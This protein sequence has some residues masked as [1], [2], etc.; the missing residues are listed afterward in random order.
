MGLPD[1]LQNDALRLSLVNACTDLIDTQVAAKGGLGGMALKTT[2]G[3]V[4]SVGPEYIP[5]AVGRL[6]PEVL[7]AL[8]PI[9]AEGLQT[10]SP[11][12]YLMAQSAR[13]ADSLLSVTD[14]R[15]VK[16]SN[17]LVK[18]SYQRLRQSV[19]G[20]VEAAVP[21]LAQI[22]ANHTSQPS[23]TSLN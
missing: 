15:I 2:Y 3:L 13:T 14:D 19:K 12:A 17:G 6:L 7:A 18:A 10:G 16:A 21:D 8:D 9:W 11:T 4:K 22:L 1:L 5:G 20:D 23:A